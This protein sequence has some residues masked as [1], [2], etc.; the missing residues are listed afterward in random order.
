MSGHERSAS[1]GF[2]SS[3]Q[4][5]TWSV[6]YSLT[7]TPNSDNDQQVAFSVNIPLSRWLSN[8]WATY[9]LNSAKNGNTVHQV[10]IGGTALEDNN[11][12]YNLQQSYT[13]H[14]TGYGASMTGRYRGSYGEIGANY[15]YAKD[16]KQW[17]YS[18]Q[19]SVVA[20]PYG[21]TLGQSVQMLLL[22]SILTR[23]QMLKSRICKV[24]TLT[25][26]EMR[27]YHI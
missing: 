15:S 5:I 9:N 2:S 12:S 22:L 19:G 11:L 7:K 13:D 17:N 3:W 18:A 23:E 1:M 4:D 8:S 26:G 24:F 10:G 6:N 16:S 20:H 25:T 14:D 27:S 21:I